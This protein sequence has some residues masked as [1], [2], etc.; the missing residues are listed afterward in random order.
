MKKQAF[1]LVI[2]AAAVFALSLS[3][4]PVIG[5]GRANSAIQVYVA[6]QGLIYDSIGLTPLPP[7][8]PFQELI[9]GAGPGGIPATEYGPGDVGYLGGR[10]WVDANGNGE[11]D[12]GDDYF[13]CPLL[14]P[15]VP[16]IL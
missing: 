7:K 2:V 5:K 15:G 10:W 13:M 14:G 6:G 3:V 8:G 16:P 11:Q 9:P 12:E 4:S 1:T